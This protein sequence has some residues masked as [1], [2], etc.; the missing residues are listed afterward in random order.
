MEDIGEFLRLRNAIRQASDAVSEDARGSSG[1]ALPEAYRRFLE[2]AIEV[3]PEEHVS[4]LTRICPDIDPQRLGGVSGAT[5]AVIQSQLFVEAKVLLGGLAGFLDG[6]IE[7][8][9][10]RIEAEERARLAAES[11]GQYL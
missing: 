10:L 8:T 3:I 6:Y 11:G 1:A 4:E 7:E 9:T 5:G 2:A